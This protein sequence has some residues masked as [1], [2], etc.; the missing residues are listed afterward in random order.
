MKRI[1][2]LV[3]VATAAALV[4]WSQEAGLRAAE[5]TPPDQPPGA[6]AGPVRGVRGQA[7]G[8]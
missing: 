2:Q 4:S 8:H 1:H 5:Q 6:A 3:L 7:D